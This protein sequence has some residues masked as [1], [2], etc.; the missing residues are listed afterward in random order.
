MIHSLPL[1]NAGPNTAQF[2]LFLCLNLLLGLLVLRRKMVAGKNDEDDTYIGDLP[3]SAFSRLDHPA[4]K[5]E[6]EINPL[7][8]AEVYAIY[9]RMHDA[10]RVLDIAMREGRISAEEVVRF[11]SGR[12]RA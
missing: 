7:T 3:M 9:G 5:H 4:F 12:Q 2:A 10:Q 1:M 11:W 8:E 6:E